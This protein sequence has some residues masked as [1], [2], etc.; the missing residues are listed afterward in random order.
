MFT[1]ADMNADG[2]L[3][4][5]EIAKLL[6]TNP[7]L[8]QGLGDVDENLGRDKIV[9]YVISSVDFDREVP[10][11]AQLLNTEPAVDNGKISQQEYLFSVSQAQN[12][13]NHVV[14]T[15]AEAQEKGVATLQKRQ[16]RTCLIPLLS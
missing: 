16:S 4:A 15:A 3:D 10:W 6:G 2:Y 1:I 7:T 14:E 11:F 5:T 9:D 8:L 13:T 12:T